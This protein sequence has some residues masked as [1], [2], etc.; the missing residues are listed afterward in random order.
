MNE[1]I[2]SGRIEGILDELFISISDENYALISKIVA[3]Y[4]LNEYGDYKND[5]V[6]RVMFKLFKVEE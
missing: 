6:D 5:D 1:I 2:M 3:N 4:L